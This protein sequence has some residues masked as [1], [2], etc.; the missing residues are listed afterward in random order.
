LTTLYGRDFAEVYSSH[1][2]NAFSARVADRLPRVLARLRV[3]PHRV[4][5]LT[6]G[7]GTFAIKMAKKGYRMT[8]VD[9]SSAM[10]AV[11]RRKAREAHVRVR[12]IERDVRSLRFHEEFDLVTSWYDSLNYLLRL[13]D[14]EKTFAGTF[15]ALRPGGVL[16]F[17]MNTPG[18][19]AKGWQR[20]P[21]FVE[22]DT[23]DAFVVH[24]STWDARKHVATL[25]VTC[26]AV[27]N[28]RWLRIDEIHRERAYTLPQIRACLRKVGLREL[29]CWGSF[30][31]LTPPRRGGRKYWFACRREGPLD[32]EESPVRQLDSGS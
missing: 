16:L 5:D 32:R 29:A 8:G 22:V 15:R 23:R 31:D 9:R 25:R 17:D 26:F 30:R 13:D 1:G 19:L 7:E 24:R 27:R 4:L 10:L 6:C 20:H 2:Y 28:G 11:A 18:T 3:K 21:S 12:F 14:L